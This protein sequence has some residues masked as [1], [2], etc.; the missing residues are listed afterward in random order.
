MTAKENF[1]RKFREKTTCC[2]RL[3]GLYNKY[4]SDKKYV[5]KRKLEHALLGAVFR[6]CE[7]VYLLRA[8]EVLLIDT[9]MF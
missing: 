3:I 1:F 4:A 6:R 7:V 5:S 9:P 8:R 2:I